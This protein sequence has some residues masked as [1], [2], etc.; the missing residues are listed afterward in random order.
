MTLIERIPHLTDEEVVNMLGNARRL[1]DVG[2]EK[3]RAQAAEILPAL[4]EAAQS[5]RAARLEAAAARRARTPRK[6][7]AV[8]TH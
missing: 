5:R 1:A 3:Q 7:A 8:V 6:R 2:E 4:E